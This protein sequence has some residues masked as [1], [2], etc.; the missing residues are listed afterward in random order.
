VVV[1]ADDD[2]PSEYFG[3]SGWKGDSRRISALVEF[4]GSSRFSGKLA[5]G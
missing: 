5:F 2:V 4:A 3:T 1:R